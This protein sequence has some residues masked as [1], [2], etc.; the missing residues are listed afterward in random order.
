VGKSSW[1]VSWHF[2][3][4][5]ELESK[6]GRN[7]R[8]KIFVLYGWLWLAQKFLKEVIGKTAKENLEKGTPLNCQHINK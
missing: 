4:S 3:N 8:K 2:I 6:K 5:P 7:L 1:G